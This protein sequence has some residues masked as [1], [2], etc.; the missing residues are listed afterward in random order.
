[1]SITGVSL[2]LEDEKRNYI[3]TKTLKHLKETDPARYALIC[4]MNLPHTGKRAKYE[5]D[6]DAHIAS[7]SGI[8]TDT[9]TTLKAKSGQS[10]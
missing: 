3:T 9:D 8:I 1:M 4:S 5:I 7:K 10:N 6:I 2:E